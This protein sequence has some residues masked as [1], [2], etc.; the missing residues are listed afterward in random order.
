[1]A[2]DQKSWRVPFGNLAIEG[3][4]RRVAWLSRS[5]VAPPRVAS[6]RRRLQ[7]GGYC[8]V[9]PVEGVP[10]V[11]RIRS[12]R[13]AIQSHSARKGKLLLRKPHDSCLGESAAAGGAEHADILWLVGF[14]QFAIDRD[15]VDNGGDSSG[16]A[17][18]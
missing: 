16:P 13:A 3:R 15:D 9:Q 8:R 1:S 2:G 5:C 10:H 17:P 18:I 14:Q 12:A 4:G 7:G 11:A 6:P